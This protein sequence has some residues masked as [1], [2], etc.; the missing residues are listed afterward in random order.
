M[1]SRNRPGF[2][3]LELLVVMA[4]VTIAASVV[5]PTIGKSLAQSRLTRAAGLMAIDLQ[6][7][8]SMAARQRTPVRISIDSTHRIFRVR[9]F[10]TP[11]RIFLE[12]YY[13]GDDNNLAV[14]R[15]IVSDTSLV[16]YPSGLAAGDLQVD[17]RTGSHAR[18]V[19]LSRAGQ[20][21]V[22]PL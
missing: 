15:M 4:V 18:R 14:G 20:V 16:V 9:D 2:S 5:M 7:A 17:F 22:K 10:T 8:H 21:R 1:Q 12:R 13:A 6:V 19:T 11:S 3:L